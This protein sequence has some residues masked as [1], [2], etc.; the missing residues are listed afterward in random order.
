MTSEKYG[1][2]RSRLRSFYRISI[3]IACV[4]IIS[5]SGH[6]LSRD[7]YFFNNI[8]RTFRAKLLPFSSIIGQ[9]KYN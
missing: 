6:G 2:R 5:N 3:Q 8:H 4:N 1:Q 7:D 9:P